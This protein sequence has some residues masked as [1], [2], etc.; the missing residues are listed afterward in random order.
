MTQILPNSLN[1]QGFQAYIKYLALKRHFTTD[2]Y[3]YHKYN[4]KV[5]AK[6]ESFRTRNDA[7]YFAKLAAKEDYENLIMSNMI[8]KPNTWVRDI[9]DTPGEQCYVE[10]KKRIDS[11]GHTFK[12]ELSKLDDDYQKN[13]VCSN[14]RHPFVMTLLI[15]KRIS[16]ETFTILCHISNIFPYWDKNLVDKFVG[17]DIIRLS[18]KYKPFLIFDNKRFQEIIKDRFLL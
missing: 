5:R 8:V 3:D 1:E 14:G 4:G 18:K 2:S 7:Y 6:F 13:F 10:W 12:T 15:Q 16:L 9:L 11:L 17:C